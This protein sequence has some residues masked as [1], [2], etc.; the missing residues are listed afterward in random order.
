MRSDGHLPTT[1][2]VSAGELLQFFHSLYKNS[3]EIV[4]IFLSH[5]LSGAIEAAQMVKQMAP[6]L[7]LHIVDSRNAVIAEGF[8][9]LETARAATAGAT[10]DQ[11][12]ARA[13]EMIPRVQVMATIETLEYMRRGGRL[14]AASAL[15]G[16][17][18]QMKPIIG[19]PPGHGTVIAY[20]K[21]RTWKHGIERMVKLM[22][23]RVGGR[24]LHVEIGHGG[25][26]D[27]AMA[28]AEELRH[29]FDVRELYTVYFT[30]VMGA[31]TGPVLSLAFYAEDDKTKYII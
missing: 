16:S 22:A 2:I 1:S 31:H 21:P 11:V 6:T 24:P 25:H 5:E 8:V 9:V 3:K 17:M 19:I 12:I 30:P 20:A 26:K 18:L 14:G 27:E 29:R 23:E 28:L 10:V 13:K 7:P 15:L 4:A